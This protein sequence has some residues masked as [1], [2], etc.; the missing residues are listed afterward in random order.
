MTSPAVSPG[1]PQLLTAIRDE[2]AARGPMPFTRFMELALYHPQWGYYTSPDA[3]ERIGRRGDFYTNVSVGAVFGGLLAMQFAEMWEAM[4]K[5]ETFTLLELGA[6]RGQLAADLRDWVKHNYPDFAAALNVVTLD[7]PGTLPNAI[8]GCIFSNELVDALPVHLITRRSDEWLELFVTEENGCLA[9]APAPFSTDALRDEV[10]RLTLPDS[11]DFVT[12]VHLEAGRWI[13][14]VAR[15]L[16]RGFVM[17]I[18]YGCS[19]AA[20]YAPHRKVGTLLCYHQH[21]SNNDPLVRVGEQDITAHINFT[22]LAER[23]AASGLPLLGFC[24]QSRFVAGLMEKAGADFLARLAP[25]AAGQL[26]TLLHPEL[27]GQTFKVLMQ[28]RGMEA[29]RLSGLKFARKDALT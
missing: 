15:S 12:E 18:D 7:Y 14:R 13:E 6:H 17:T 24:D 4:G 3:P 20:Y 26:K 22:A 11:D 5:P 10:S 25:K 23:G 27:M 2:I 8:T 19:A 16:Q 21:R 29:T 28:H 9:F 1:R